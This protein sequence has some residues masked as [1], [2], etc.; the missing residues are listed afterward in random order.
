MESSPAS[1]YKTKTNCNLSGIIKIED[2][3]ISNDIIS[4]LQLDRLFQYFNRF[5]MQYPFKGIVS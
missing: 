5:Q 2:A 1:L 3:T 4:I